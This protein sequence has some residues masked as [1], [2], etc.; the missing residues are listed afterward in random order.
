LRGPARGVLTGYPFPRDGRTLLDVDTTNE[1]YETLELSADAGLTLAVQTAEAGSASQDAL[2]I[3]SG[4]A[5]PAAA[6][7]APGA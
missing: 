2:D 1:T 4:G 5:A 6:A 7:T 3:L